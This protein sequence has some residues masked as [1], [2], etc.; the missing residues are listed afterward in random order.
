MPSLLD[1]IMILD[2]LMLIP[3]YP[4]LCKIHFVRL[5]MPSYSFQERKHMYHHSKTLTKIYLEIILVTIFD[6]FF[7]NMLSGI[8]QMTTR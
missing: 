5:S 7:Q 3:L 2:S 6:H 4:M 8:L 1:N